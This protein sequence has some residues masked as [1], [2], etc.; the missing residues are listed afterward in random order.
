[1]QDQGLT[2]RQCLV[3]KKNTLVLGRQDYQWIHEPILYGWKEGAG[4]FFVNDRGFTTVIELDKKD[5]NN[6]SK[7]ELIKVIKELSVPEQ[8]TSIIEEDK[9]A[10]NP[11]HPTMKPIRLI[12]RLVANSSKPGE[13]TIDTFGGSG[14]TLIACEQLG[15]SCYMMEL[16][17]KYVDVIIDRWETFTGQRAIK[18]EAK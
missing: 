8:A 12:G 3:W 2:V 16:D 14:S 6:M 15:R 9:P 11:L 1:M 17:P 18:E 13:L 5:L 7:Q 4:H 10:K